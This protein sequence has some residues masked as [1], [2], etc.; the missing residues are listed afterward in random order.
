MTWWKK[1]ESLL[2]EDTSTG[3]AKFS[4][5]DGLRGVAVLTVF[6][7]HS[8]GFNQRIVPWLNFGRSDISASTCSSR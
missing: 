3:G 7:S 5:L 1:L 2:F 6:L 4:S 8:S